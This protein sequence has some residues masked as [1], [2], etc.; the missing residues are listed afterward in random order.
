MKK[1]SDI[2]KRYNKCNKKKNPS[3]GSGIWIVVLL[4]GMLIAVTFATNYKEERDTYMGDYYQTKFILEDLTEATDVYEELECYRNC[5]RLEKQIKV[6]DI[7]GKEML[8][9]LVDADCSK[10]STDIVWRFD[11]KDCTKGELG[12]SCNNTRGKLE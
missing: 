7:H 10:C 11:V 4:I 9:T 6:Y 5:N 2:R 3:N 12:W 8:N 1:K